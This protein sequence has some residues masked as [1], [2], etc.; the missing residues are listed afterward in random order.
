MLS[1]VW[2]RIF[3]SSVGGDGGLCLC[4]VDANGYMNKMIKINK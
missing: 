3:A 2:V 1:T 4:N